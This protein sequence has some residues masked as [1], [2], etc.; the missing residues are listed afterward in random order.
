MSSNQLLRYLLVGLV[1][2][3]VGYGCI[4]LLRYGLHWHDLAANTAGYALGACVSYVLNRSYTFRSR[5]QHRH[6]L[7]RFVLMVGLCYALNAGVLLLAL[8]WLGLPSYVGQA[9]AMVTYNVAF[10]VI[11]R[12]FVF[13]SPAHS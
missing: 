1:N 8:H 13:N 9:L 12:Q 7:P 6:A 10:F 5:N 3:A 11:S 2:T 4:L